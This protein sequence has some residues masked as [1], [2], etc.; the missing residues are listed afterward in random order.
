MGV[1][2]LGGGR[3]RGE[4]EELGMLSLEVRWLR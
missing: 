4:P 1:R 2:V 3:Q